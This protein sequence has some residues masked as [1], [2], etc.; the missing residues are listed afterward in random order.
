MVRFSKEGSIAFLTP[1]A[2]NINKSSMLGLL[3]N[4]LVSFPHHESYYNHISE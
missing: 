3:G 2:A 4:G 1:P